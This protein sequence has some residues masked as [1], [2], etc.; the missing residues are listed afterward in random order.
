[1]SKQQAV[2]MNSPEHKGMHSTVITRT[3]NIFFDRTLRFLQH[4]ALNTL[5]LRVSSLPS[6]PDQA[7]ILEIVKIVPLSK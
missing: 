2:S 4:S 5:S 3:V 6:V 1:M 7:L